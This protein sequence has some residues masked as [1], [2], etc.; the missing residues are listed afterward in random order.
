M[1]V[2]YFLFLAPS[3]MS[4]TAKIIYI[5]VFYILYG[6]LVTAITMPMMALVPAMTKKDSER[7]KIMQ[8]GI[9]MTAIAF[10]I[11]SSF[12]TNFVEIFGGYGPL[13]LIYGV[14]MVLVL[15]CFV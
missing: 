13:M 7:S 15:L 1:I 4:D 8:L 5:A 9:I 14:L 11:A 3:G 12:T 2:S 6:M 10:T